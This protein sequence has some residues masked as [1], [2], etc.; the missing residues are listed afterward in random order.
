MYIHAFL[1]NKKQIFTSLVRNRR[2]GKLRSVKPEFE[3]E[4]VLN[5]FFKI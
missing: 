1:K 5:L 2:Y 4:T 3:I